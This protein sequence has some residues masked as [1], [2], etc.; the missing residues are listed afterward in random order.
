L[1][2]LL[3]AVGRCRA[4]PEKALFE[5]YQKRLGWVLQLKEVEEKRPLPAGERILREGELIRAALPKGAVVVVLDE[6]GRNLTSVDF[7]SQLGGW[8]DS[9]RHDVV[10]VIGGA[11]GHADLIRQSADLLLSFGTMTWPH[12]LVRGLL[13]E[14]L[15]RAE[16]ILANHPYHRT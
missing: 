4:G 1:N 15:Y 16:S 7:A 3:L 14:Q 11:D 10:F 13:A 5:H 8:R 2:I 9:G 12:M 6:R